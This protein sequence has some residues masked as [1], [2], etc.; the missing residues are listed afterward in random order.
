MYDE[1]IK[2]GYPYSM[3]S[4]VGY[5]I[6]LLILLWWLPVIGPIIVGY[7]TGR[8]AGGPV[9]GMIAMIVP[10]LLYFFIVYAIAVGWVNIPPVIQGYF[11][12]SFIGGL[13]NSTFIPYFRETVSATMEF[14]TATRAYLYY[15]P[16][17][18]FIM[19]AFAFIG[20]TISRQIILER[21]YGLRDVKNHIPRTGF[22][23]PEERKRSRIL[24]KERKV[25]RRAPEDMRRDSRFVVHPM[26]TRKKAP[27][28]KDRRYG[29]TFL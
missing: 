15:A 7:V 22:V 6:T 20:G 18:F 16:S 27:V 24:V 28:T 5:S 10:I 1:V 23:P 9:K 13:V 2:M 17:S 12:G 19:I 14:A 25:K 21:R 4:A 8:K 26:D 29:I 3:K 11:N